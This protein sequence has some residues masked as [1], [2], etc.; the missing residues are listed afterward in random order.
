MT[1]TQQPT[2]IRVDLPTSIEPEQPGDK[3]FLSVIV[4]YRDNPSGLARLLDS[5]STQ[6]LPHHRWELIIVDNGS[7]KQN[8]PELDGYKF[9]KLIVEPRFGAYAARN[10][11]IEQAKGSVL[12]FTDSDCIPDSNWLE[13]IHNA[14]SKNHDLEAIGGR[15]R[16]RIETSKPDSAQLHESIFAFPQHHYINKLGYAATANM[17]VR[18]SCF[19]KVGCFQKALLSNGDEEWGQRYIESGGKWH[20]LETAVVDHPARKVNARLTKTFRIARGKIDRMNGRIWMLKV[21]L[22]AI[23]YITPRP[24]SWHTVFRNSELS[25]PNKWRIICFDLVLNLSRLVAILYWTWMRLLGLRSEKLS[26]KSVIVDQ[27]ASIHQLQKT[28]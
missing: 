7:L 15:I 13:N 18:K 5:I 27:S 10:A 25:L 24:F 23:Y 14:F 3:L 21:L 26:S 11:G 6:T 2:A 20:Y 28:E 22:K 12:V 8:R 19:E 16:I 4:P 17:A 9:A 1:S